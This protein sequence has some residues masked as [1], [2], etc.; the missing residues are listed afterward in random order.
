MLKITEITNQIEWNSQLSKMPHAHVLQTWEWGQFKYE[1]TGWYPHRWAIQKN[2]EI[3]AMCS[4]GERKI[5]L[6]SMMYAPKG[7]ATDYSNLELLTEVFSLLQQK[8]KEH[9]AI[10]LKIDPDIPYATGV[11]DEEDDS[12]CDIGSKVKNHLEE[13]NWHFSDDQIQFQNTVTIDLSQSEDAI[14][15]AMSG[16]TRRK[17]RTAE[18]RGVTIRNGSLDNLDTLYELYTTTGER[19]DFLIRPKDYYLKLWRYF[20]ENDL[21]QALIAEYENKPI[22]HV[23]LFHFGQTCWYFYGASSNEERER[24]PN[25]ALQWEAMKWAKKRGYTVYDMWGAPNEFNEDDPMW[26]VFAFKRGFR[27]T[28]ER[29]LGAWDYAPNLLLYKLYTEA[30]PRLREVL[31][32]RS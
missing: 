18:K 17:V 3:V 15:A 29:R 20:M 9:R 31:R 22:A 4:M 26:G 10:W 19:N 14:W 24:M 25:Y 32:K 5:G 13:N 8:A 7:P 6:F 30:W 28:V 16:N 21:A 2:D 11:P 27:G 12:S 1:T 23:I